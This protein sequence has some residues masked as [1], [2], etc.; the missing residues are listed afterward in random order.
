LRISRAPGGG[1]RLHAVLPVSEGSVE[2]AAG[3][4]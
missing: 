2:F 1:T 3:K 4:K